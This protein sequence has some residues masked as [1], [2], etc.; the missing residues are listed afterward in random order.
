MQK[1]LALDLLGGTVVKAAEAIGINPSAISQWPDE[2]S[3]RLADRVIA[4]C[5]RKGV[6]LPKAALLVRA[7]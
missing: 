4:A 2:L 5:V 3:P 1:K 7:A 6:K